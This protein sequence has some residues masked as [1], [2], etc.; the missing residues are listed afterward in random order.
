MFSKIIQFAGVAVISGVIASTVTSHAVQSP[1]DEVD[2]LPT[3]TTQRDITNSPYGD[4]VTPEVE[5]K[6]SE[7]TKKLTP[8]P[9]GEQLAPYTPPIDWRTG[10]LIEFNMPMVEGQ[11]NWSGK[12]IK[13]YSED[14]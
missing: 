4:S 2:E 11:E 7:P 5:Q 13:C 12:Q 1:P 3:T 14:I 9:E 6:L 8:P 10:E